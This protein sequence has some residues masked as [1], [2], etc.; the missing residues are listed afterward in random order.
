MTSCLTTQFCPHGTRVYGITCNY[1]RDNYQ[2]YNNPNITC[3]RPDGM[4]FDCCSSQSN[5]QDCCSSEYSTLSPTLEPTEYSCLNQCGSVYLTDNCYWYEKQNKHMI[6][7][8]E[9]NN[10]K[11]CSY[12]RSDCCPFRQNEFILL[13]SLLCVLLLLGFVYV[14]LIYEKK[15]VSHRRVN[16]LLMV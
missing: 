13:T 4:G 5:H 8:D 16:P 9:F 6:C 10:F 3:T 11:C 12:K 7:R 14:Y 1:W 15:C 2:Y